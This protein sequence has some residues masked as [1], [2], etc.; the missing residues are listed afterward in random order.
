M[1]K[2][3]KLYNV[4][5]IDYKLEEMCPLRIS[6][7]MMDVFIHNCNYDINIEDTKITLCVLYVCVV[8]EGSVFMWCMYV[9]FVCG[10]CVW[11]LCVV[12]VCGVCVWCCV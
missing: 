12:Y 9:V 10:V 5:N 1:K 11:C 8:F 4:V 3:Y 7:I 2:I 6:I